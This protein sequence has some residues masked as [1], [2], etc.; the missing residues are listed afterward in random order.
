[1]ASVKLYNAQVNIML[2]S[3]MTAELRRS[4]CCC[5]LQTGSQHVDMTYPAPVMVSVLLAARLTTSVTS[6][7]PMADVFR[8][9]S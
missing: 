8:S 7:L 1:M 2:M 9:L 6:T 5:V 4:V 3:H